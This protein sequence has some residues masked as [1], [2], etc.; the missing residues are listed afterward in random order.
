[1]SFFTTPHWSNLSDLQVSSDASGAIGFAAYL[2][3]L[4]F[5]RRWHPPQL[6]ASIAF[7]ELYP[8]VVAAH[9]W[10]PNWRGLK[11]Q[12]LCDNRGVANVIAKRF[13]SNGVL[14]GLLHSLF[15]AAAPHSFWVSATHMPGCLNAIADA[16]SRFQLQ[17]FETLAPLAFPEPTALPTTLLEQLNSL[18]F[19]SE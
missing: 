11:V 2:N 16:L 15:L 7:K 9:V 13:C 12:F 10:G 1:M 14:G 5:Y 19:D 17:R 18:S 8:I 3:G 4:W 6:S